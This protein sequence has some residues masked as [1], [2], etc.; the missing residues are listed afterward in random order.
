MDKQDHLASK[1]NST[2]I[3]IPT[4]IIIG[5]VLISV[6]VLISGGIIKIK[7]VGSGNNALNA[8]AGGQVVQASSAPVAAPDNTPVKVSFDDDPVQGNK[9]APLTMVEF[10]DYECPFCKR[11]FTDTLPELRKDYIDS[12]KMKVVY[13]DLPLSFHQN[14]HIEAEAANCAREQGGDSAYFKMHDEM[15]SKTTSNGTGL[16]V[17]E[18]PTLANNV[19]L[20]GG[21]LKTC[22]DSGKYKA[23]VDKDLA[24]AQNVG[25]DGT[26]TFFI[27]KSDN[28]FINGTRIVGAQPF[29][30]FKAIIDQQLAE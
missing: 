3:S 11:Y 30:A 8:N 6:S 5:S 17:D 15:F 16:S 4:A 19:G 25:A 26:P 14:A 13:R 10:S 22:L 28:G 29:S 12:G 21:L 2:F 1:E 9:N 24:D 27:G 23:E 7:G 18:L 20:N